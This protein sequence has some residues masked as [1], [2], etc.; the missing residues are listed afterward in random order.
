VPKTH[1]EWLVVANDFAKK[2][3]VPNCVG[4]T[5]RKHISVQAPIGSGSN[6]INC[7]KFFSIILFSV[8]DANYNFLYVNV[9]SQGRNYDGGVFIQTSFKRL[10]VDCN[11]SLP[12]DCVL[13]RLRYANFVRILSRRCFPADT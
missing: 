1:E 12:S 2:W 9:S 8:V 11:P 10:L 3:N 13:T 4:A 7:K 6:Y 5:D